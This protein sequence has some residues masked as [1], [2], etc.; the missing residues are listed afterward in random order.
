MIIE[1]CVLIGL[2]QKIKSVIS[3]IS[4]HQIAFFAYMSKNVPINTIS[5]YKTLVYDRVK[6][7]QETDMT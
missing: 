7:T 1:K 4:G 2:S 3:Y 5:K 6:L